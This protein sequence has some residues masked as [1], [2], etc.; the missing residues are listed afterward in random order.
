MHTR[1]QLTRTDLR[2]HALFAV[3]NLMQNNP[4]NQAVIAQM[5][6]V[7]V[8]SDTGEVLPVPD[9]M[10]RRRDAAEESGANGHIA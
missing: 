4:E 10:R 2:E 3:R 1:E 7:G 5:D 9:S 6:P 8:L